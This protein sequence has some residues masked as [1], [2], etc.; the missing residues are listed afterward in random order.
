[1]RIDKDYLVAVFDYALRGYSPEWCDT[2]VLA[3]VVMGYLDEDYYGDDCSSIEDLL[4]DDVCDALDRICESFDQCDY[5][6]DTSVDNLWK[7]YQVN[8]RDIDDYMCMIGMEHDMF[9]SVSDYVTT[10]TRMY[11]FS[12]IDNVAGI[13]KRNA[14]Y[15][16]LSHYTV[17]VAIN[18]EVSQKKESYALLPDL[19]DEW[20]EWLEYEY[21]ATP[22]VGT[23]RGTTSIFG[24]WE[25]GTEVSITI[26][27][28]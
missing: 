8:S 19:I 26:D 17:T 28:A 20:V 4:E 23:V 15:D 21:E 25:D 24:V 2:D 10:A 5:P 18:G 14:V 1:M 16:E 13:I 11:M 3:K 27:E 7:E 6:L 22:D 12:D 9:D